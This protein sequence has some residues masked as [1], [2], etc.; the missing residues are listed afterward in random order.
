MGIKYSWF[1]CTQIQ[2]TNS[3]VYLDKK[4]KKEYF[5]GICYRASIK[6]SIC[7]YLYSSVVVMFIIHGIAAKLLTHNA[8]EY[9]W[10]IKTTWHVCLPSKFSDNALHIKRAV[11]LL[12]FTDI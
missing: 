1:L 12:T 6:F 10:E 8:V 7:I 2:I 5:I 4:K 11:D 3:R 9:T